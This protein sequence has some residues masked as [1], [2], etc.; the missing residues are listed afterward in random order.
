MVIKGNPQCIL[1]L[2]NIIYVQVDQ[3]IDVLGRVDDVMGNIEN[4][5]YRVL[6]DQTIQKMLQS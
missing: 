3:K 2:H 6:I 5:F 4:P 1:D